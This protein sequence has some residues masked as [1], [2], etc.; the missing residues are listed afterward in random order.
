M[1]QSQGVKSEKLTLYNSDEYLPKVSI[2]GS[3]AGILATLEENLINDAEEVW[4]SVQLD[5]A[6]L[7]FI[8]N[9]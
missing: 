3:L 1:R 7:G 8:V 2:P 9:I 4:H 6:D 5:W